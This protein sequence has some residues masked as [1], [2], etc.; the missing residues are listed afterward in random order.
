MASLSDI[1]LN[2][3]LYKDNSGNGANPFGFLGGNNSNGSSFYGNPPATNVAP[4]TV[5][6]SCLIQTSPGNDRVE[7]NQADPVFNGESLT[8][9]RNGVAVVV[10]NRFGIYTLQ[11]INV[12]GPFIYG[13]YAQ[14]TMIGGGFVN[15]VGTPGGVFPTGWTVINLSPGRYQ[16]T[17]NI[18]NTNYCVLATVL[19]AT[20]REFSIEAQTNTTFI[21]RI[22]DNATASLTDQDFS[23]LVFTNP[24]P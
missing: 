23:F 5:I 24:Q 2:R 4:G 20:T 12:N 17:H 9:Y 10:I 19:S 1:G 15:A 22:Y 21:M 16:V 8:A 3:F 6:A 11:P 14:P 7:L 13:G 18:G